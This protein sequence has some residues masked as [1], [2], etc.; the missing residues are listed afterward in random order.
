MLRLLPIALL[1]A[2]CTKVP[3]GESDQLN[4]IE[5]SLN[6]I[7]AN[8]HQLPAPMTKQEYEQIPAGTKFLAPDGT[9]RKKPAQ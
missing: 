2:G 4:R 6:R 1:L 5:S 8:Q 9:T 7:E 3:D